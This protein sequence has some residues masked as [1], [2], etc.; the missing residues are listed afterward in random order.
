MSG[1]SSPC[2]VSNEQCDDD[3]N[4]A[5]EGGNLASHRGNLVVGLAN[6]PGTPTA[7]RCRQCWLSKG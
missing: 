6:L 4:G 2:P 3:D 5:D 7:R 1:G